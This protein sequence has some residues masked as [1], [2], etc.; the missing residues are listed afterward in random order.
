MAIKTVPTMGPTPG[1]VTPI[2]HSPLSEGVR[3][4]GYNKLAA[5]QRKGISASKVLAG[6]QSSPGSNNGFSLGSRVSGT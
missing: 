5:H 6:Y 2:R 4:D 3:D 1:P